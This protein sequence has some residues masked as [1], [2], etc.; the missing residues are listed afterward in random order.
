MYAAFLGICVALILNFLLCH[1]KL[2][3]YETVKSQKTNNTQ[4]P[5]TK[6]QNNGAFEK[7]GVVLKIGI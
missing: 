6:I 3:F 4:I 5:M 2:T 7:R 1:L